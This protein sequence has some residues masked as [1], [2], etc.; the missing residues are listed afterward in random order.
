M[1]KIGESS[2]TYQLKTRK[3][4]H[5]QLIPIPKNSLECKTM[6]TPVFIKVA[7]QI[8]EQEMLGLKTFFPL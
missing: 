4:K 3:Q 8:E 6:K 5:Q 2:E 7:Q 1:M